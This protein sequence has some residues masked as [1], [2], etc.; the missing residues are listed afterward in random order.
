MYKEKKISFVI[1]CYKSAK[2][3]GHVVSMIYDEF[4][5]SEYNI[6]IVLVNDG[7][8]DDTFDVISNLAT[9]HKEIIAV[10]LGR[11][12]GQ[13]AATICGYNYA[14]GDYIVT[15]DDDGQN[16]PKEAHK[17]LEKMDEGYDAV[18]GKYHE[19]KDSAFKKWG[20]NVNGWMATSFIGKPKELD[21]QSYFAMNSYLRKEVV[22]YKGSYPYIWGLMLRA[23]SNMA[24]VYIEHEEREEGKST[25]TLGKLIKNWVDGF[26]GFSIKPLRIAT[27]MGMMFAILGF[28]LLIV[29]VVERFLHPEE[30]EGWTS[31][32]SVISILG[33]VQLITIGVVGEYVGRVFSINSNAPQFA[34]RDVINGQEEE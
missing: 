12:F 34:V 7:S 32:I 14:S 2:T 6:E 29:V 16:P 3:I 21:L 20:H 27:V 9:E 10:N 25:Y 26:L 23:S 8:G 24:N 17:L 18:F 1:P 33:G 30:I 22:K 11:N 28:V 19:K 31:L 5:T 13:D 4:P 15:L